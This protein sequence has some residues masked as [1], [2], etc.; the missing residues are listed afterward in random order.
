MYLSPG[1]MISP[2][3]VTAIK[4]RIPIKMQ[5]VIMDQRERKFL[6][7]LNRGPIVFMIKLKLDL[8]QSLEKQVKIVLK[9]LEPIPQLQQWKSLML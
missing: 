7:E 3:G 5:T 4:S 9:I 6:L 8:Q 2:D 1:E